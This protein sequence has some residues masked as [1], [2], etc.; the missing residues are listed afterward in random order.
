MKEFPNLNRYTL[1][2]TRCIKSLNFK[3]L[4]FKFL[5]LFLLFS[6]SP[7]LLSPPCFAQKTKPKEPER[8]MVFNIKDYQD[9]KAFLVIHYK[10]KFLLKDSAVNNGKG[11]FVFENNEKLDDGMYSLIS[12]KRVRLLDF[13]LDRNQKFTFNLDTTGN[14]LNFSV[15]NSSENAEMLR[16]QQ[17]TVEAK[18]KMMDWDKKRTEFESRGKKDSADFYFELMKEMNREM[19]LFITDLIKRNPTYL[20]SKFQKS[21]REIEIPEPPVYPDGSIDSIFQIVYYRTHY[22]DNFDLTDRRFLFLPSY[23]PRLNNYFKKILWHLEADTINRYADLMLEKTTSDSLMYRFLVEYLLREFE[24]SKVP[25]HDAVFVHLANTNVLAGKCKWIDEDLFK[26]YKMR[27]EDLEPLLIGKKSVEMI[28]PDTTQTDVFSK[29]ISSYKMPKKYRILWFYEHT[30]PT[31]QKEAKV[32]K[33][34]YDSL[35]KIGKL[36]FDVYAVNRTDDIARWKKYIIDNGYTWINVGGGKGSVDWT[37]AYRISTY[38][39]FYI[40][41]QDKTIILNREID[42]NLIPLFLEEYEKQEAEKTRLKNKRQ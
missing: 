23:E 39:Q 22:W 27:I 30:C 11:V 32:L 42:K 6:F 36:N 41:N 13:I 28:L 29:W 25:G 26:K 9:D 1:H 34:V 33:V 2:V 20:F 17:K 3:S 10:D 8:R 14:V 24:L 16:F 4:N 37:K 31:C 5:N 18:K 15:Q 21:Y 19:E 35:E 38:P 7:F 12:K 40:I